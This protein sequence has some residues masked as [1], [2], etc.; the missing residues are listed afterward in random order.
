M[1]QQKR[2]SERA[3]TFNPRDNI[4]KLIEEFD[5][6][7][8]FITSLARGLTVMQAFSQRV[9]QLTVSQISS[10]VGISR[11]A[12]RRSLLT[13]V[14]LGFACTHDEQHY[15]LSPKVL[16]LGH[17]YFSSTPL[18]RVAQPALE[19]LSTLLYE[20]C[21]IATLDRY[22]VFYMAR[23]AVSRIMSV[24]LK[25]GSRLPAFC[26]SM[27]R[28]LL[29]DLPMDRLEKYLKNVTL[30]QYTDRTVDSTVR[31]QR[32]LEITKRQGYAIVDQ[33]LEIGLR[34]LAV[35]IRNR[36]GETV[37]ALNVGCHAQ[38]INLREMQT[39]FLPHMQEA[40]RTIAAKL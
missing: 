11:A 40:A 21:S 16:S 27:G 31:L 1:K 15:F 22:E 34:S 6:D 39:I 7:R 4:A 12:V 13:L 18:A 8:D 3:S 28:V 32:V 35:P 5:G 20:S 36:S 14:K 2:I 23:A 37:A 33:E 10:Q 24:D 38:R 19:H 29:A 30:T 25:V 26:T 17:A 9:R